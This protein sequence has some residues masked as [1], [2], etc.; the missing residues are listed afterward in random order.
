MKGLYKYGMTMMVFIGF[1][2]KTDTKDG[3]VNNLIINKQT[4]L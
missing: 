4:T 3:V 1:Q 2:F